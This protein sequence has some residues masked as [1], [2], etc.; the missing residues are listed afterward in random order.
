VVISVISSP[1][2]PCI[3]LLASSIATCAASSHPFWELPIIYITLPHESF[4]E[5]ELPIIIKFVK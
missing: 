3:V 2:I 1:C 5:Y 4:K